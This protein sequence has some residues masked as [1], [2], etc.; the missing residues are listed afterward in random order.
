[1]LTTLR[2][3]TT[4][5]A[6]RRAVHASL[7][8]LA[9]SSTS[10]NRGGVVAAHRF[11]H[12]KAAKL[13]SNVA[14]TPRQASFASGSSDNPPNMDRPVNVFGRPLTQCGTN[15]ITGFYRDGVSKPSLYHSYLFSIRT[16]TLI[17]FL[18]HFLF[19]RIVLQYR[20]SR[21]RLAHRSSSRL[22]EMA[23]LFRLQR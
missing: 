15:P 18:L 12:H 23:R 7:F 16:L 13:N 17:V 2:T 19:R 4:G 9:L 14:G 5:S 8:L 1:M 6:R 21:R 20:P 3:T 11:S 10:A 22:P